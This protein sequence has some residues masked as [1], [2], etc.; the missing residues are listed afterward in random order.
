MVDPDRVDEALLLGRAALSPSAAAKGRHRAALFGGNA[1][2]AASDTVSRGGRQG[3]WATPRSS[4]AGSALMGAALLAAGVAIGFWLRGAVDA[5]EGASVVSAPRPLSD[6]GATGSVGLVSSV[7][8]MRAGDSSEPGASSRPQPA[9]SEADSAALAGGTPTPTAKARPAP[10]RRARR[11]TVAPEQSPASLPSV[12]PR[13]A[14]QEELELLQRVERAIR[15]SNFEFALA[16]LDE[17]D[18]RFPNSRLH[19]E[20]IAAR[21]IADCRLERPGSRLRA[22]SFIAQHPKSVYSE[23]L[24]I[25]CAPTDET[26]GTGH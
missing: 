5:S 13:T 23:R 25:A 24:Q 21:A 22:E 3:P 6:S 4:S 26:A 8:A 15:A 11:A 14:L 10:A 19:E 20:R 17:L 7:G 1:S 16:L 18:T 9:H 12:P 2:Q